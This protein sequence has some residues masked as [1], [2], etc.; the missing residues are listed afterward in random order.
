MK[1]KELKQKCKKLKRRVKDLEDVLAKKGPDEYTAKME[2]DIRATMDKN[3]EL[4]AIV[5]E[6]D[7]MLV[8]AAQAV[9]VANA[10]VRKLTGDV[11]FAEAE[12]RRLVPADVLEKEQAALRNNGQRMHMMGPDGRDI[13]FRLKT[14]DEMK[15]EI[16]RH[17][18]ENFYRAKPNDG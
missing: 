3:M 17:G 18:S 4:Q 15:E 14:E 6:K 16:A 7:R 9:N 13:Q 12:L 5:E 8:A 1:K 11:E 2:E 10:Q